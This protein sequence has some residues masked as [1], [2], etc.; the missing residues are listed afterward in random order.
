MRGFQGHEGRYVTQIVFIQ[1]NL[2]ELLPVASQKTEIFGM[3]FIAYITSRLLIFRIL[4]LFG[5]ARRELL[6]MRVFLLPIARDLS[7]LGDL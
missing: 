4:V 6:S 3:S 7:L 1:M 2:L 5:G